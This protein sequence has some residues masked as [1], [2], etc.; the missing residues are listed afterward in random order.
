M[1]S[2]KRREKR[3]HTACKK[4]GCLAVKFTSPNWA[5]LPDRIVFIP[6]GKIKLA[7]IKGDDGSISPIQR[8]VFRLLASLGHPVAILDTDEKVTHFLEEV[9][10]MRTMK[11]GEK[12]KSDEVQS[13]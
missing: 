1:T 12:M 9:R 3:L 11:N 6:W 5:G 10:E 2:E 7:E 13:T 4:M 8:V